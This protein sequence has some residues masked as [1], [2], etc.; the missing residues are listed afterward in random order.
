MFFPE[1]HAPLKSDEDVEEELQTFV[2]NFFCNAVLPSSTA[3]DPRQFMLTAAADC[4]TRE[5]TDNEVKESSMSDAKMESTFDNS[6]HQDRA[7]RWFRNHPDAWR[8]P[9]TAELPLPDRNDFARWWK[10]SLTEFQMA[11]KP[12]IEQSLVC[13]VTRMHVL[14][15][16]IGLW[17]TIREHED[18]SERPSI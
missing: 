8:R 4:L 6:D 5:L 12:S 17:E 3:E 7:E 15:T 2:H 18:F 16:T 13:F 14:K 9:K 10:A 1:C 11:I